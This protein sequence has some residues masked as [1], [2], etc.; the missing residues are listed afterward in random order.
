MRKKLAWKIAVGIAILAVLFTFLFHVFY[1]GH[2]HK[3]VRPITD[4]EKE[5]VRLIIGERSSQI[6]FGNVYT[7][8]GHNL[9]PVEVSELGRKKYYLVDITE[10]KILNR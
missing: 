10:N 4:A 6:S 2:F 8:S 3:N 9:V 1:F 5:S 7:S